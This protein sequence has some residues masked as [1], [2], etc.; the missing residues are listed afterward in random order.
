ILFFAICGWQ[1]SRRAQRSVT[2]CRGCLAG[3]WKQ[4]QFQARC[5][6]VE[7]L[8]PTASLFVAEGRADQRKRLHKIKSNSE[9]N[10]P[11]ERANDERIT[12]QALLLP[13]FR[14]MTKKSPNIFL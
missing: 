6:P 10:P 8:F 2:G 12:T 5:A 9:S 7:L 11:K 14:Q 13:R 4:R 1:S 3:Q